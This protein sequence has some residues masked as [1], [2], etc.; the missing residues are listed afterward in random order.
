MEM[1]G[2][3]TGILEL[4]F[5]AAHDI[6]KRTQ[7][8]A[9]HRRQC[10]QLAK[11]CGELVSTLRDQESS[12]EGSKLRD[13]VDELEEVLLKIRKRVI[14][15]AT[16]N[17]VKSFM[18]QDQIATDISV[19][20]EL[21][22]SHV[23][24]FQIVTSIELHR[25][26]RRMDLDRQNDQEEVKQMLHKLIRNV[27][28]LSAA[29]VMR[30][31][32]PA[33][34]QTIQEELTD[35]QP[36][37]E[38]YQ[39]LRGGLNTL[40]TKTGIL[41][42]LTNLTGQVTKLSEHPA[43]EGGT[44]DIYEGQWVGEEKVMLKAIRHVESESAIR[45]FRREVDIWRRLQ[46]MNILR[47]Y[48]ICYIGPRLFAV[49]PW[50]SGGNLQVY[51]RNNP[52]CDRLRLLSEV[53]LG[54]K[55]LHTFQPMI[56]HGD[57]RAANVV[58][59]AT[60]EALLADF[61]LSKIIAEE[62]GAVVASTSLANAGSSRWMAP[63]LFQ[64]DANGGVT[65]ASDVW[66][67]GMLCLEVLTG[68]APFFQKCRLDAQVI[69]VLMTKILPERP[70]P[71]DEMYSR[72]LSN[73]MWQLMQRCWAWQPSAR[74]EMRL[75]ASEVRKLHTEY[76]KHYGASS[77][78]SGNN[79]G[80]GGYAGASAG[81]FD[82]SVWG[83]TTNVNLM[84]TPPGTS[85]SPSSFNPGLF[86]DSPRT[87]NSEL[88]QPTTPISPVSRNGPGPMAI[89]RSGYRRDTVTS[90]FS[91]L[92]LSTSTDTTPSTHQW[93]S[94]FSPDAGG[95]P[96]RSNDRSPTIRRVHGFRPYPASVMSRESSVAGP[97]P[98]GEPIIN[99]DEDGNVISANLEGLV[100]RLL[101]A[102]HSARMD[103]EFRECF[104][105]V[106]RGFARVE[107]LWP[108]LIDQ[109]KEMYADFSDRDRVR[110][111][112]HM[113]IVLN[114]WLDIQAIEPKDGTFLLNMQR[115]VN[116]NWPNEASNAELNKLHGKIRS[117]LIALN[118]GNTR[119]PAS[120]NGR[121]IKLSDL[122][123][124]VVAKQLMRIESELFQKILASDCAAWVKNI[125]DEELQN[126][127]RFFKNNY[128]IEDWCLSL[129]LF[130]EAKDIERRAQMIS[131]FKRVAEECL[132]VRA[133]SS[134]HAIMSALTHAH[135]NGLD[136][137]WRLVDKRTKESLKQM[138]Q[139]LSDTEKYKAALDSDLQSPSVP[140]L[141]IHLRDLSRTYKEMQTQVRV[142]GEELVN[143]QK[144]TEVWRSINE[145]MKYQTPRVEI[146]RDP[147]A[148][149]YLEHVFAQ[150]DDSPNLQEELKARGE[151]LQKKER[152]D[153]S[154]RR[155]GM[156][157]AGFRPPKRR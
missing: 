52:D 14:E 43:A 149:V 113:L 19:F 33:L 108:M 91:G 67:F 124:S 38:D 134:A 144:F 16:L 157:D 85:S 58:V 31:D 156:E 140:I 93:P 17:R 30:D 35:E 101:Q 63:E 12:L 137:T 96:S 64:P 88:P 57:L 99:P 100:T 62:E 128:K 61:G 119:A 5:T 103:K 122:E 8:V 70:M 29:V 112:N 40:H 41:P 53:A 71:F 129:I 133:F 23:I 123:A 72:G 10:M 102:T 87:I 24:K 68:Q 153:F 135:V 54:L 116:D 73:E 130:I 49:A 142:G 104:L 2:G 32:V 132:R 97:H 141:R 48:G 60:N 28:D 3:P 69:A 84:P 56:V 89:P 75:L 11:R 22:D 138:S 20:N 81:L 143:F 126:I 105:T 127:P 18:R 109:Y 115:F 66:S 121:N 107:D 25:Q 7:E 125:A 34:M 1:L 139:L 39:A 76:L 74:P 21:L 94:A 78:G 9:V 136:Y 155:L 82:G 152:R 47:F 131:Y 114:D 79:L 106:Y 90:Q 45:R 13:A 26:Q 46:H 111:Q 83:S 154:N 98:E 6:N 77:L 55:Y 148:A 51:V 37:T 27:D 117:H 146:E 95:G 44:A 92:N 50:A 36:G 145:T 15:W 80:S 65:S 59:S 110:L 151:E 147:M 4:A 86:S 150:I 118:R 120:A 42:P